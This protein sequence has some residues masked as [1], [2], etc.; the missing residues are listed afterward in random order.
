MRVGTAELYWN[1]E[2]RNERA[3]LS[4]GGYKTRGALLLS[5]LLENRQVM[6]GERT[7]CGQIKPCWSEHTRRASLNET[8]RVIPAPCSPLS[9]PK[10]KQKYIAMPAGDSPQVLIGRYFAYNGYE[11]VSS[12]SWF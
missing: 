4:C 10:A 3:A 11:K 12:T 1:V 8:L 2:E 6:K 5:L 7:S 9:I